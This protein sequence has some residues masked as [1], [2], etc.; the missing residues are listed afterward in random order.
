ML[1]ES[2]STVINHYSG[3]YAKACFQTEVF[4][5]TGIHRMET[6]LFLTAPSI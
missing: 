2:T 3:S 1:G 6:R 4:H 5:D